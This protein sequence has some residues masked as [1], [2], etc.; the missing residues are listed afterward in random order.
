L[1][2]SLSTA[3]PMATTIT[4]R[5]TTRGMLERLKEERGAK[6]LDDLLAGFARRELGIRNSLL[7]EVKGL[8]RSFK[9]EHEDRL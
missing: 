5:Q 4:I 9:R 3:S 7:G 8:R 6:S 1:T 2:K